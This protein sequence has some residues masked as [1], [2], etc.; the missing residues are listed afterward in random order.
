MFK[1][2][3]LHYLKKHHG[4]EVA[5]EKMGDLFEDLICNDLKENHREMYNV[6]MENFHSLTDQITD[7]DICEAIE[8]LHRKDGIVGPK[9]SKD[10][11]IS[12]MHQF[13]VREKTT[14][15][16]SDVEFW[17][18]MNY[19]FASHAAPNKTMSAYIDLAMDEL[20]DKNVCFKKKMKFII[21]KIEYKEEE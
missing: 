9:W 2:K 7:E 4:D 15:H 17:A 18:A 16:F 1:N 10:E 12:V 5:F 21:E 20:F 14:E 6:F 11:V 19:A 8:H 13:N 3:F